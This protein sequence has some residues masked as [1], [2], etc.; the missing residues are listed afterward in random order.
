MESV[1]FHLLPLSKT[2]RFCRRVFFCTTAL[3]FTRSWKYWKWR[4]SIRESSFVKMRVGKLNNCL[5]KNKER[6]CSLLPRLMTSSRAIVCRTP[7]PNGVGKPV[8]HF[9]IH[10]LKKTL[11]HCCKKSN[12]HQLLYCHRYNVYFLIS[13][14]PGHLTMNY[15]C[16]IRARVSK[17]Q[18]TMMTEL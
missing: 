11:R 3:V 12:C 4:P 8:S 17:I 16:W 10:I 9:S 18:N 15:V 2:S 14:P 1:M 6:D 13:S 5:A 7:L